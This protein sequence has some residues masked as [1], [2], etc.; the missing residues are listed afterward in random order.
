MSVSIC[1][2]AVNALM[3]LALYQSD[4]PKITE[5][6]ILNPLISFDSSAINRLWNQSL[7]F[8]FTTK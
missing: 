2:N 1:V 4:E 8:G 5:A 7:G 6:S 3:L